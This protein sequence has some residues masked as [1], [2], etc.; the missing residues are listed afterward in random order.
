MSKKK[1]KA[2]EKKDNSPKPVK[3]VKTVYGEEELRRCMEAVI[4]QISGGGV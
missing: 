2:K 4:V 3:I 1:E